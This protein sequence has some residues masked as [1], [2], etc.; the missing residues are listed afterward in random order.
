MHTQKELGRVQ[1]TS[2][3]MGG[4]SQ[5]SQ[6]GPLHPPDWYPG[7]EVHV[8]EPWGHRPEQ[9]KLHAFSKLSFIA[10]VCAGVCTCVC[11]RM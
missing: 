5:K 1:R 6:A 9:A 11:A 2:R 8:A 3:K 4:E 7:S 10:C